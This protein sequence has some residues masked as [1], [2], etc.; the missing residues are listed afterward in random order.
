MLLNK[1]DKGLTTM[2][3]LGI[4][5]SKSMIRTNLLF[6]TGLVMGYDDNV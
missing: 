3:R 4:I 5:R 1:S 2:S 6:H